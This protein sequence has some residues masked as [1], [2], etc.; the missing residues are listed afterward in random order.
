MSRSGV[1][2]GG[3]QPAKANKKE[4]PENPVDAGEEGSKNREAEEPKEEASVWKESQSQA[5]QVS[6]PVPWGVGA[7][8]LCCSFKP[9]ADLC[10]TPSF[11]GPAMGCQQHPEPFMVIDV[12]RPS[13]QPKPE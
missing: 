5:S 4:V 6:L 11:V 1:D 2:P 12:P 8:S 13:R 3:G 7:S 9:C 10:P